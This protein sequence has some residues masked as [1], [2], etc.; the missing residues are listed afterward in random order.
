MRPKRIIL[1]HSATADSKTLSAGAIRHFHTVVNGWPD[2]GYHFVVENVA[3]GAGRMHSEIIVGR[4]LTEVGFHTKGKN[5]GSIG[6][7]F[8]GDF[9]VAPPPREIWLTGLRLVK[10]LCDV[11][12]IPSMHV[13]GHR[14]FSTKTCPGRQF[15]LRAFREALGF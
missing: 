12:A 14:D 9:D 15:D 6:I 4:M 10:S 7:C 5:T 13:Y 2:I 1:H 8:V 3:D 11:F